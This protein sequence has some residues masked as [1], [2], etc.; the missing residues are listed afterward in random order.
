MGRYEDLIEQA[1][2]GNLEALDSLESEFGVSTLREKAEQ[3]DTFK[4]KY[5]KALPH[6]RKARLDELA[7][8]LDDDL[9]E[10]GLGVDDF[11]DFDPDDLSLEA[12][13]DKAKAKSEQAQ[14]SKLA[15]AQEAG[16]DSV[17]EYDQA[18]QT[19]KEQKEQRKTGMEEV[20][21]GVTSSGGEP[22]GTDEPTVF[23]QGKEAFEAAKLEGRADDHA[24]SDAIDA[25]LSAQAPAEES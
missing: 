16:F 17:E 25:I 3:A 23:E 5:E 24:M 6:M 14:A 9:R 7:A 2:E 18:L 22:A 20:A 21:S 19:F 1:R 15:A 8:K 11:G 4:S 12:V 10:V 13:Q